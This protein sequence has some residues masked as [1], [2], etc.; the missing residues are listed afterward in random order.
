[1][2]SNLKT[3]LSATF[4]AFVL[5]ACATQNQGA[6]GIYA[7]PPQQL[8]S[9]P[10][11]SMYRTLELTSNSTSKREVGEAR[12]VADG[13]YV[14]VRLPGA[15]TAQRLFIQ[16]ED[17]RNS[18]DPLCQR[19]FVLSGDL[20]AFASRLKCY[21]QIRNDVNSG[22]VGQALQGLCQDTNSRSFA[23]TLSR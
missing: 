8:E 16:V 1:M 18:T 10:D 20:S 2:N 19:R 22:Y 15:T 21:I 5:A 14:E 3:S 17:C 13:A 9:S 4:V 6:A 12:F 23:V 7:P 11:L